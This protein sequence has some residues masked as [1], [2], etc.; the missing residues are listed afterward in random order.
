MRQ[1]NE[2]GLGRGLGKRTCR[3]F[4]CSSILG[5]VDYLAHCIKHYLLVHL[6]KYKVKWKMSKAIDMLRSC[7]LAPEEVYELYCQK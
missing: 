6:N 2:L 4:W 3:L 1:M 5:W 7:I